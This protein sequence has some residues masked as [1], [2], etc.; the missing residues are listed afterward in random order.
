MNAPA[1]AERRADGTTLG[2]GTRECH[3]SPTSGRVVVNARARNGSSFDHS[4]VTLDEVRRTTRDPS[5]P[6]SS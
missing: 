6:F 4:F 5:D 2:L 3:N 1:A